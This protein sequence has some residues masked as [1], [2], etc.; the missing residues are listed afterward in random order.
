[1]QEPQ[2]ENLTGSMREVALADWEVAKSLLVASDAALVVVK[3]GEEILRDTG[4]GVLP[5][6]RV[7]SNAPREKLLGAALADKAIGRAA[8][9]LAVRAGFAAV[10]S[11]LMSEP[12]RAL[13]GAY[14]VAVYYDKLVPNI[15]RPNSADLCPMEQLV[16]D[17]EE[18]E[19]AYHRLT[20]FFREKGVF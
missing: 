18:P 5:L 1:M 7:V 9:F 16:L 6:L 17:A 3:N 8:A 2:G 20:K 14:G 11:P 12:A 19:E 4:K 10:Y 15:L 13:L